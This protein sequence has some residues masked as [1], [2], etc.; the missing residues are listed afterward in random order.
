M[1]K[2][3]L[4]GQLAS[5]GDCLYATTIAKQIKH[6]YPDSHITWAVATRY[7]TILNLNPHVD[8]IWEIPPTYGDI[9]TVGWKR[10][11]KEALQ[12]KKL[13][14][15]DEII[16]SQIAPRW[17]QFKGTIR[18]TT[19]SAYNKPITVDPSPVVR[20]SDEEVEHVRL[21]AEK[22]NLQSFKK[23][24]LFECSP[25][26]GQSKH[27]TIEFALSVAKLVTRVL[28]DICFILSSPTKIETGNNHIIDASELSFRENAELTKYC[29]LLVGCSS[30]ISWIATS[31][32]AK[33]LPMIQL[34]DRNYGLF[35]GIKY[36][37]TLHELAHD[38][39]LEV[40][41]P[42]KESIGDCITLVLQGNFQEAKEKYHE[43]YT[44]SYENFRSMIILL[45]K[46][47]HP[48]AGLAMLLR[49][50]KTHTHLSLKR[51]ILYFVGA[52]WLFLL[53]ALKKGAQYLLTKERWADAT[54]D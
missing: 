9:F 45:L 14:E 54:A 5:Y 7:K 30:G 16:L 48:F 49:Y 38:H 17:I 50:K 53:L 35:Y 19:L 20:L 18:G 29:D 32:W 39:I 15:F 25:T 41:T 43:S 47:K 27:V 46:N 2:K 24:V 8:E 23:V 22:N 51:L 42:S 1:S 4:I 21:F 31:D 37:H 3:I 40:F 12:R 36:D 34:L 33:K 26:S 13:G 11:K 52:Y 6:D 28:P 44:V 10:F